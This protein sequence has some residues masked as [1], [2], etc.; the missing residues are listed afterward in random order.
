MNVSHCFLRVPQFGIMKKAKMI[1]VCLGFAELPCFMG[2]NCVMF[3]PYLSTEHSTLH[4]ANV[5]VMVNFTGQL[6]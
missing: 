1:P 3:M 2:G 6:D 5:Y 4:T